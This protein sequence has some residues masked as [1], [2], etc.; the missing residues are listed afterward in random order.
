MDDMSEPTNRNVIANA[1]EAA[2]IFL[3]IMNTPYLCD[4]HFEFDAGK[5][6]APLIT[7]TVKQFAIG[8]EE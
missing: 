1:E 5:G 3:N 8:K 7:Y 6:R 4:V 2:R